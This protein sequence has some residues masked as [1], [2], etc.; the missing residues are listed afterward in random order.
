MD[1]LD[2]AGA[3]ILVVEDDRSMREMICFVLSEAGFQTEPASD[4]ETAIELIT[5]AVAEG[6]LYDVI[7]SDIVMGSTSGLTVTRVARDQEHPPEVILLT[8]YG[9]L[10]TA[11]EAINVGRLGI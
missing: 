8:G 3:Y 11:V 1:R 2:L 10:E 5:R 4:G 7:V 6:H 9:N